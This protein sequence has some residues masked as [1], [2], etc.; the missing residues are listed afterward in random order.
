MSDSVDDT[1]HSRVSH[2]THSGF[3]SAAC[4][5]DEYMLSPHHAVA[6]P[7]HAVASPHHGTQ[8]PYN[9]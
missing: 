1:E 3:V 9:V 2:T 5:S 6:S 4:D 7:H 8:P